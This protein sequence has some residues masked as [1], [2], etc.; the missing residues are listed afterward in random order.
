MPYVDLH[1]ADDYASIF[2]T[3]NTPH[4]NVGGFDPRK[5]SIIILH[6]LFLDSTWLHLQFGDPRLT[7]NYNLIAFDM[8]VAGKSVAR[9]SAHHD[10]WVDA[11]DLAFCHQ[12]LHLP[13]CHI[14]AL[15]G[16]SVNCALRFAVLF[17]EMCLS[18]TLCNVPAPTELKWV[19]T[20]YDELMHN[21]CS[22]E[23]LEAYEHVAKEAVTFVVGPQCEAD[24]QDDLIA[25]WEITMPPQKIAPVVETLCVLMHR[26]P[27]PPQAL[28]TITQPVLLI[29]GQMNETC[30]K[31]NAEKLAAEL[32][33]AQGGAVIYSVKGGAGN[34]SIVPGH[35]SI[36]NKVFATFLSRQPHQRSEL[37]PPET[38][39]IER[40]KTALAALAEIIGD[41]SIASRDPTSSLS[42][43]CL[44]HD[45]CRR[46]T[47][48][49][50]KYRDRKTGTFTP[51][52]PDGRPVRRYSDRKAGHWFH[53]EKDG[54]SIAGNTFLP[55]EKKNYDRDRSEKP[56][57]SQESAPDQRLRRGTVT[58]STVQKQVIKGSMAKV[59]STAPA[60]GHLHRLVA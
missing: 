34:L 59:V 28:A 13:P 35:A 4:G 40:M 1:C 49:L 48:I 15:D 30:P 3:T 36:M 47:E 50:N 56:S 60:A 55:P 20:A 7:S 52:G 12:A 51:V 33:N 38:D 9:L 24:L 53:G 32:T 27:V 43:S 21:W 16:I 44:P 39:K 22:A 46:Q 17:P 10:S 18:L 29:Q 31:I 23:D 26:Q 8:R 45:A 5:P 58:A 42:F 37:V 57:S 6:P 54:L 2:Y 41:S 11:A 25:Y 14:L 19:V